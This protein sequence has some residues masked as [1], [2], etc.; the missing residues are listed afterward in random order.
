MAR[1]GGGGEPPPAARGDPPVD[2]AR[3]GRAG[4][5]SH[6]G[7]GAPVTAPA[8]V[9]GVAPIF[10]VRDLNAALEF[11]GRLGFTVRCYTG[12]DYGYAAL[13]PAEIHLG[14]AP[15]GVARGS[16]YL[17]VDD[18]DLL[19]RAWAATGADV[20]A[21]EDTPWRRREGVLIDPAG[22]VIRFGS[23]LGG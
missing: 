8:S 15:L 6:P 16:A 2:D 1:K 14:V 18:A 10:P 11:Y 23:I 20:R 22:N 4:A 13:G 9:R 7:G 17:F 5:G 21:P 3:L 12:G 19:A